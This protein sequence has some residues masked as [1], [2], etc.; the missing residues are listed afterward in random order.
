MSKGRGKGR[1][2]GGGRRRQAMPEMPVRDPSC[3]RYARVERLL[4]NGRVR[5][6][7]DDGASRQ[8]RIRGS[9]RRRVWVRV[10]D[11]V[12]VTLRQ[13]GSAGED[14]KADLVHRYEAAEVDS[15]RRLGEPVRIA[16]DEEEAEFDKYVEFQNDGDDAAAPPIRRRAGGGDQ[17]GP[18]PS[19]DEDDDDEGYSDSDMEWERI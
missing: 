17:P 12:L 2:G 1:G 10:G 4:G 3:Q 9:M 6:L 16:V 19:S 15:L 11:V 7:C 18:T 14:D 8:C 5:A 13:F